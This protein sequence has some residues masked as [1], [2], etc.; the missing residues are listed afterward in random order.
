MSWHSFSSSPAGKRKTTTLRSVWRKRR[1]MKCFTRKKAWHG[2][3]IEQSL[4]EAKYRTSLN[5]KEY[6]R[7]HWIETMTKKKMWHAVG[8]R[9]SER[10]AR[11]FLK[12]RASETLL[13]SCTKRRV[14]FSLKNQKFKCTYIKYFYLIFL[15]FLKSF[16]N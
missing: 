2:T 7:K 14:R 10:Q 4:S 8:R 13:A 15:W 12:L 9:T 1:R 16:Y 5:E 3:P 6:K 11:A